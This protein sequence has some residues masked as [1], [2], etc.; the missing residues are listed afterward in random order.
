MLVDDLE[1]AEREVTVSGKPTP[2]VAPT[3]GGGVTLGIAFWRLQALYEDKLSSA[4]SL[5]SMLSVGRDRLTNRGLVAGLKKAAEVGVDELEVVSDSQLVVEQMLLH[6]VLEQ[7]RIALR[8]DETLGQLLS[9]DG[10]RVDLAFDGEQAVQQAAAHQP[11]VAVL[12][13]LMPRLDGRQVASQLRARAT[14][15]TTRPRPWRT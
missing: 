13:L 1:F 14:A 9:L 5:S 7:Q 10:H 8:V 6:D 3:S 15:A 11:D 12:D 2:F 4:V